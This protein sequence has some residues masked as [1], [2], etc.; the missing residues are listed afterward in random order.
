MVCLQ[1]LACSGFIGSSVR[2]ST[3]NHSRGM[4]AGTL[5]AYL[6]TA[7]ES[8]GHPSLHRNSA[9]EDYAKSLRKRLFA[10]VLIDTSWQNT[11]G[12]TQLA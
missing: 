12:R 4:L 5:T 3:G 1:K 8:V 9:S 11:A 2:E 6:G 10:T 7:G